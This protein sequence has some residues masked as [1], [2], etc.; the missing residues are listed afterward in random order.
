MIHGGQ[1]WVAGVPGISRAAMRAA[2]VLPAVS[3]TREASA[4]RA[5]GDGRARR[6]DRRDRSGAL[7]SATALA[8]IAVGILCAAHGELAAAG[9]AVTAMAAVYGALRSPEALLA[10]WFAVSPWAS[11]ILRYP[12]ERSIVTFDRLVVV[13]VAV[14]LLARRWRGGSLRGPNL[15]EAAWA[16]YTVVALLSVLAL[17]AENGY[18]LRIAVD[19]F[20]LPLLLFYALRSG[21]DPRQGG[22]ALL[23]GAI[24]LALALPWVGVYEF[25]AGRDVIAYA[26]GEIYRDG[27]VR[28]NGP[29]PSDISYTIVST[30]VVLCLEWMPRAFGLQVA[31]PARWVWRGAQ[32]A[33][34]VA[35]LL[36]LFRTVV[37]A[38]AG[39]LVLGYLLTGRA[40]GLARVSIVMMLVGVAALPLLPRASETPTFR[41]RVA[42]PSSAYSRLAT[43]LSGAEVIGDH[44]LTGVGLAN[45]RG[46]FDEKYETARDLDEVEGVRAANSPHNNVLGAWAELGLAGVFFYLLATV[47]LFAS[48]LR[49]RSAFALSLLAA[50]AV[51]GLTLQS[52]VYP[53]A[54]LYYFC[55]LG[56]AL[57]GLE[58]PDSDPV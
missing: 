57:G 23:W 58:T 28:T 55:A 17:S 20:A 34:V 18:A 48:A 30:L 8:L 47:A 33:A 29:F 50:Y 49:R 3:E 40:R 54:S 56:V 45:Y 46:Y 19:A 24:I 6:H 51:I 21:F 9:L 37:I 52:S 41:N 26:G 4:C 14:G 15:F 13:A 10:C 27:I 25:F 43:F 39:A 38:L 36:P 12:A 2:L 42:D 7:L 5:G 1:W 11:Y 35:A 22:R 16:C 31:G 32:T 44:P 53:E